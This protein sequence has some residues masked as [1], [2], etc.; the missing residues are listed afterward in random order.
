M[1]EEIKNEAFTEEELREIRRRK[2]A[3]KKKR[4]EKKKAREEERL[5]ALLEDEEVTAI[6]ETPEERQVRLYTRAQKKMSFAPHMY[7]RE[8]QADMYCQAAE[9][10]AKV[11]GFEQADVLCEECRE[12]AK[13]HRE[14]Y[15]TE[16]NERISERLKTAMTLSD[17]EKIRADLQAIADECDVS[18]QAADCARIEAQITKK[19]RN[20][21]II[22]IFLAGVVILAVLIVIIYIQNLLQIGNIL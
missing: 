11:S 22:K 5:R 4:L 15:M 3:L 1:D 21:K 10:F 16:M 9:L 8:D 20:R 19:L 14:L 2:R 6:V 18:A 13:R 7:C 12:Q 17:C